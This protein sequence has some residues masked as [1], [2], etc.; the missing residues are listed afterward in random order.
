MSTDVHAIGYMQGRLSALVDGKIQAFPWREWQQEFPQAQALGLGLM[1]WTL[2]HARL[3]ENPL[4]TGTGRREIAAL[5][6]RHGV[7]VGSVTGDIFMQAP[8]WRVDG[9]VRAHR[10]REFDAVLDA[11]TAAGIRYV[12]V[13]LVD[14]GAMTTPEEETLVVQELLSRAPR[15]RRDGL[16]VVFECDYRPADLARFIS[17]LPADVL[18]INYDIGNS[19]ALD[20]DPAEEVGAYG[21]R[22]MNVHIKDRLK[23]GTTVPLGTGNA[24][25]PR[26][27]RLI[28]RG[29]YRGRFILQTARSQDDRHAEVLARYLELT[30]TWIRQAAA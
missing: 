9:E 16:A 17:R 28:V 12:V 13:P 29:G 10:L 18:G 24:D 26:A 2:D 15:L 8:F 5:S 3:E 21:A 19:A 6:A 27:L 22:I 11:C 25:L 20:Y 7:N 1:E 23:G 14:N 4:M 30:R